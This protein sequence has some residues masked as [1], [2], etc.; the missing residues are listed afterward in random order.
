MI[1]IVIVSDELTDVWMTG[2]QVQDGNL[3]MWS[4]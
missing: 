3:S 4:L 1:D 2:N